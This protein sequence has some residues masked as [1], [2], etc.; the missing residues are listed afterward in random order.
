MSTTVVSPFHL[1]HLAKIIDRSRHTKA[2]V[3]VAGDVASVFSLPLPVDIPLYL[4]LCFKCVRWVLDVNN[5]NDIAVPRLLQY[6]TLS[7][8]KVTT[9][10]ITIYLLLAGIS[11]QSLTAV[12]AF[13]ISGRHWNIN[14]LIVHVLPPLPST[15]AYPVYDSTRELNVGQRTV[16]LQGQN[17]SA[18]HGSNK[19]LAKNAS[20]QFKPNFLRFNISFAA[21]ISLQT[22]DDSKSLSLSYETRLRLAEIWRI[23]A[24]RTSHA[25]SRCLSARWPHVA[26]DS[27]LAGEKVWGVLLLIRTGSSVRDLRLEK[28]WPICCMS[29]IGGHYANN[30]RCG[31]LLLS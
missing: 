25:S 5:S 24:Q 26:A 20:R 28:P 17:I 31:F 1:S 12:T 4:S 18:P 13:A 14:S 2:R 27:D 19:S 8:C 15:L 23:L 9:L 16:L 29:A 3:A 22:I 7:P 21:G 11:P 30:Y 6:F 10:H